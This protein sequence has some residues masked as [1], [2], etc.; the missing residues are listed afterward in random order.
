MSNTLYDIELDITDAP[1]YHSSHTIVTPPPPH[2]CTINQQSSTHESF[3]YPFEDGEDDDTALITITTMHNKEIEILWVEGVSKKMKEGSRV[4]L[5][6]KDKI[7]RVLGTLRRSAEK[8]TVLCIAEDGQ[9]I[10]LVVEKEHY[11]LPWREAVTRYF[12]VTFFPC[13]LL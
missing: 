8:Q 3:N 5:K 9:T 4:I 1:H 10:G 2:P 13:L 11:E 7:Y 6:G 12:L